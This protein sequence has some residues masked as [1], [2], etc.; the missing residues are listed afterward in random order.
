MS[1]YFFRC[2]FNSNRCSWDKWCKVRWA[3]ICIHRSFNGERVLG[4]E[5]LVFI[6]N[7]SF[8]FTILFFQ[9][10]DLWG[11]LEAGYL[12][13]NFK[14]NGRFGECLNFTE[15][16]R[17]VGVVQ[18]QYC[19]TSWTL[20]SKDGIPKTLNIP[21]AILDEKKNNFFLPTNG[22]CIPAVCS[23]EKVLDFANLFMNPINLKAIK[24]WCHIKDELPLD[25]VDKAALWVSFKL[26]LFSVLFHQ[27]FHFSV[28]IT[29]IG[30]FVLT[31]TAYDMC[32]RFKNRRVHNFFIAF[33]VYTNSRKLFSVDRSKSSKI[34][35]CLDGLKVIS[36]L[37]II[38]F[39]RN[40]S[41]TTVS[42]ANILEYV[43]SRKS[44]WS[45]LYEWPTFCVDTFLLIG[46]F[47]SAKQ[48]LSSFEKKTFNY[49]KS[50]FRRYIRYMPVLVASTLIYQS[51]SRHVK[52]WED[53]EPT[54]SCFCYWW[55]MLLL[56]QNY[57]NP[58]TMCA[59]HSWYLCVD[60]Q[61]FILTPLLIKPARK[62]GWKYLW[63]LLALAIMSSISV[64]LTCLSINNLPNP[65][66]ESNADYNA[67]VY[68]RT[69]TRMAPWL[70]GMT[71][72]YIIYESQARDIKMNKKLVM[73]LW[74]LALAV[75]AILI[76]LVHLFTQFEDSHMTV[77]ENAIFKGFSRLFWSLSVAWIIFAC[78]KL[79]SGGVIRW[80]LSLPE[81]QPLGRLSLTMY[82]I[83][84]FYQRLTIQKEFSLLT[85]EFWPLVWTYFFDILKPNST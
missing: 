15:R 55:S 8:N 81:W 75:L 6:H 84:V 82:I 26:Y 30:I 62:Y 9:V 67:L 85:H 73:F 20:K 57:V 70:I 49:L 38:L 43:R 60:F 24:V 69:H 13:G 7:K 29:I 44:Y 27:V 32:S 41:Q 61:L 83:H 52:G 33:S 37:C 35:N 46:G 66:D 45:V 36:F 4:I 48:C 64:V 40:L 21:D 68:Y 72:A 58:K 65:F 77:M 74:I 53:V 54:D 17:D 34:I 23:P 42:S 12:W 56:I 39:H 16:V 11:K 22:I 76:V 5:T 78:H 63:C 2:Y 18:G 14:S 50:I 80:L 28:F 59:I 19:R 79:K 3:V 71:M 1:S 10:F 31:S 25:N 51:L 47:L